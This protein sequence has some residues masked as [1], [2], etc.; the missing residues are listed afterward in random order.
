MSRRRRTPVTQPKSPASRTAVKP[1]PARGIWQAGNAAVSAWLGEVRIHQDSDARAE[2]DALGASAFTR[3]A[4]IFLGSNAPSL[5]SPAGQKLLAH[6]MAHVEQ[7]RRAGRVDEGRV[8]QPGDAFEQAAEHGGG[9]PAGVPA[10]TQR[11]FIDKNVM[12]GQQ[13]ENAVRSFLDENMGDKQHEVPA[14]IKTR[15]VR[16]AQYPVPGLKGK[17]DPGAPLRGGMLE[18]ELSSNLV[19]TKPADLAKWMTARLPKQM[20]PAAFAELNQKMIKTPPLSGLARALDII[21]KSTPATPNFPEQ[22]SNFNPGGR[23][24]ADV[25]RQGMAT[26]ETIKNLPAGQI[27]D[28]GQ[29]IFK[30][31]K[32]PQPPAKPPG[33][34]PRQA[35]SADK[36]DQ[37]NSAAIDLA[38]PSV[39]LTSLL[40]G[41]PK[42]K[43]SVELR[44]PASY[45]NAGPQDRERLFQDLLRT[46]ALLREHKPGAGAGVA[47]VKVYF[48]DTLVRSLPVGG[49]AK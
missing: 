24:D 23:T 35:D 32:K 21:D 39:Q 14:W 4:E 26:G 12:T 44:L 3:D 28:A 37:S 36:P 6:E 7:Q 47:E 11:Q 1:P 46:I 2:A 41:A 38:G 45:A 25:S 31:D 17:P 15:L 19:P 40:D 8:S 49:G 9:Q 34:P 33:K 5:Q 30:K 43:T 20:D 16:L 48:G 27:L 10:G 18:R 29:K 42:G 13:I 22:Q